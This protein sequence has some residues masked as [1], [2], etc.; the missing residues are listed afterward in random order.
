MMNMAIQLGNFRHMGLREDDLDP[1][2]KSEVQMYRREY[3]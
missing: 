1:D 2:Y 3:I